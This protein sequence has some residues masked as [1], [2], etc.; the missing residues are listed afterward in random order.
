MD[1]PLGQEGSHYRSPLRWRKR[2]AFSG[3][4]L[5]LVILASVTFGV[6]PSGL[7]SWSGSPG[8]P[9]APAGADAPADR[10]T[11]APA[12]PA[13]PTASEAPAAPASPAA[14]V[15]SESPAATATLA[16]EP[17]GLATAVPENLQNKI[18]RI[19]KGANG[20]RIGVALAA[21]AG[22]ET[23]TYGDAS[24]F[25]AAS[26]AKL[27]TAA[28]YYHLVE[29][30]KATMEQK[31]GSYSAA[32][33]LKSMIN[34]S[35][36]DSWHLLMNAVGYPALTQYAASIGITYDPRQ[37]R[38]T[39]AEMALF[40][41]QLYA[42][43]LLNPENTR[44]LL[45]YMQNT[46]VEAFIPAATRPDITVYH[47]YGQVY[48][49]LHDVALLSFRDTTYAL[50]I[51]TE[52]ADSRDQARRIRMIHSLTKTIV[53]ALFPSPAPSP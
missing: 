31:L 49:N 44:Q 51:Y 45:S 1:L 50:V 40:L 17:K 20:Y 26:T 30:G 14:P 7:S 16:A 28:A 6:A 19:L 10:A 38:L 8:E 41:K 5:A 24:A 52:S 3:G 35:N 13:E 4:A 25:V 53:E 42:G 48:G 34:I 9:P 37:N 43:D 29:T 11:S 39:P 32:F 47:K 33:Q 27:I 46:N 2:L 23:R 36:N 21:V 22:G 18:D 12:A 15:A